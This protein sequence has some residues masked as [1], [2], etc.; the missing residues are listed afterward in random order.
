MN[1]HGPY[2]VR[3]YYGHQETEEGAY[4]AFEAVD[5]NGKIDEDEIAEKLAALLDITVL[6]ERFGWNS[7]LIRL[8]PSV[9]QRIEDNALKGYFA[10]QREVTQE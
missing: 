2:Q 4:H 6:D 3:L 10:S 5:P 9:V 1:G 7:M 8:P